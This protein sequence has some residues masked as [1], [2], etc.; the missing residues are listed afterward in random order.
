MKNSSDLRDEMIRVFQQV[1]AKKM[2]LQMGES[3]ANIAGK[4]IDS[5]KME[6]LY[7]SLTKDEA[8]IPFVAHAG[9]HGGK[10]AQLPAASSASPKE[11]RHAAAAK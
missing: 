2:T 1:K 6:L 5:V 9:K 7:V 3:L 10:L 8:N 11:L 4:I